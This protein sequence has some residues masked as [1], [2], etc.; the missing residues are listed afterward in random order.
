MKKIGKQKVTTPVLLSLIKTFL[1]SNEFLIYENK[2]IIDKKNE[3]LY[4]KII[5][6]FGERNLNLH[7]ILNV[8][9]VAK[10][11]KTNPGQILDI[12]KI[13]QDLS[14]INETWVYDNDKTRNRLYNLLQKFLIL[15]LQ[16][17]NFRFMMPLKEIK[18]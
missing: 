5:E 9:F 6:N 3:P 17:T 7:G 1:K 16:L 8:N 15:I 2:Q 18:D 14:S 10:K 4:K 12:L 13:K 11:L